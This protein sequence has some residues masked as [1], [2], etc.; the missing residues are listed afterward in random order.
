MGAKKPSPRE[1]ESKTCPRCEVERPMMDFAIDRRRPDGRSGIC[2]LCKR[3]WDN[4]RKE[5]E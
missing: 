5:R 4:S 3:A 1:R 2:K